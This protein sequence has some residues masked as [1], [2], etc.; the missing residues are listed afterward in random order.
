[1]NTLRR[2]RNLWIPCVTTIVLGCFSDAVAQ[3]RYHVEDLG[4][5]HDGF[6]GCTMGVNN[7]GWTETQYGLLDAGKLVKGRVA[8]NVEGFTFPLPTL[9]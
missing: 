2:L 6:F 1:M 7:H 8:I 9:G 3:V 5:L 4:T